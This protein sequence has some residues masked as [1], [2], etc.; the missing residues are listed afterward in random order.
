MELRCG[1][2]E[3][4]LG[5][6]DLCLLNLQPGV[7][8]LV[9]TLH[10]QLRS[11]VWRSKPANRLRSWSIIPLDRKGHRVLNNAHRVVLVDYLPRALALDL[12][13]ISC[14]FMEERAGE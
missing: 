10:S 13:A 9:C 5:P 2:A 6:K 11:G 14:R 8:Y 4:L 1:A 7:H 3:P 12:P